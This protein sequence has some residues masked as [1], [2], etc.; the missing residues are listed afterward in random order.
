MKARSHYDTAL[1]AEYA[2][3]TLRGPARRQFER[4]LERESALGQEVNRWQTVLGHLDNSIQPV[5]PPDRVWQKIT[6]SLP[7]EKRE[8]KT[9]RWHYLGWAMA[10]SFAGALLFQISQQPP[11]LQA[12]AV[13]NSS[14]VQQGSWVVALNRS[15]SEL[16]IQSLNAGSLPAD[17]NFELWLIPPG[18]KPQS[19]GLIQASGK[20]RIALAA[21]RLT[22][23]PTLAISLEPKGGSPTGQPTGPVMY[24]GQVSAG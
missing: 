24:S 15:K 19:L 6:Q 18:Q 14:N 17:H 21:E 4:R 11:E 7:A 16:T 8:Q 2:L 5:A 22:A 1:A 9:F 12:I 13:L 20:T 23:E 10:A 3:G